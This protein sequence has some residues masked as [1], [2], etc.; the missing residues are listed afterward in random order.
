MSSLKHIFLFHGVYR[1]RNAANLIIRSASAK[2]YKSD[3]GDG[4]ALAASGRSGVKCW[5]C[6]SDINNPIFKCGSCGKL[7]DCLKDQKHV[8]FFKLL[9]VEHNFEV[10]ALELS[11]KFRELQ[12]Q[13]HPDKFAGKDDEREKVNSV[14]WSTLLN[15]AYKTL[16]APLPRGEII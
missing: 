2:R 6:G 13:V 1:N 12:S 4:A 15:K 11:K 9:Q 14:D 10:N 16:S 8:D 7:Q 3:V 5:N